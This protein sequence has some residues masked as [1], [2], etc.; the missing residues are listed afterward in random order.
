VLAFLYADLIVLPLLDVYRKYYGLKMA[1]YIGLVFYVTMALS[2]IVMDAVFNA[3]HLV[4][5]PGGEIRAMLTHFSLDYTFWLNLLFG[6]LALWFIVL[7][8]RNPMDHGHH[9]HH[10]HAHDG[11]HGGH[12]DGHGDHD[13]HGHD[14]RDAGEPGS[15]AVP[16]AAVK[17]D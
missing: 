6:A 7:N 14:L 11:A 1:A 13:D 15:G 16:P 3:L 8:A 9:D 2:A 4:P 17:T 5:K 12:D 10:D